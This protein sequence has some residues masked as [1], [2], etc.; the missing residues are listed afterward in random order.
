MPWIETMGSEL[1]PFAL[2]R[3]SALHWN[4]ERRRV[5]STWLGEFLKIRRARYARIRNRIADIRQPAD[6]DDEALEAQAEARVR[7]RAVAA[8][9]AIPLVVRGI[10]LELPHAR[11]E[12]VEALLALRAADDLADARRE[13][14]HR[15][16]G[17]A[18]VVE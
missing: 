6:I 9:V 3:D 17:L 4:D 2:A 14:I 8:E 16:D 13:Y 5:F 11:I 10:E 12:H 7:H 1:M 15:G 18:V